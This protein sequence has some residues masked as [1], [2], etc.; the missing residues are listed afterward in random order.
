M[1][2]CPKDVLIPVHSRSMS[3][4]NIIAVNVSVWRKL[5][6]Y[7]GPGTDEKVLIEILCT[8]SNE[9]IKQIKADYHK[10]RR[11]LCFI[12]ICILRILA[13][14]YNIY[15]IFVIWHTHILN[16]SWFVVCVIGHLHIK[17][18][19][20]LQLV[21]A[22][23][24]FCHMIFSRALI[25]EVKIKIV[26]VEFSR[27]LEK[28]VVSETSGYFRR[29]LVSVLTAG[30]DESSGVDSSKAEKDA[31]DIYAVLIQPFCSLPYLW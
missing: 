10:G 7:Q 17:R 19:F 2:A 31:Q 26:Y 28:D 5:L 8:K 21:V 6:F 14:L 11:N 3:Q 27:D 9:Q 18:T 12:S 16:S 22:C 29:V 24:I 15:N 13:L 4:M 30:R 1:S 25:W 23:C 20:W